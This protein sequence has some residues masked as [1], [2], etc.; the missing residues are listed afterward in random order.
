MPDSVIVEFYK[1]VH[2]REPTQEEI[3][4]L[5]DYGSNPKRSKLVVT[6]PPGYWVKRM[7]KLSMDTCEYFQM[8]N[9]V[10]VHSVRQFSFI[11]SDNPRLI[12]PPKHN[13]PFMGVGLVT[14][15]AVKIVP[16]N[17]HICLHMYDVGERWTTLHMETDDKDSIRF[18]NYNIAR[19]ARR[20]IFSS[21][22]GKLEVII[23]KDRLASVPSKSHFSID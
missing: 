9:W 11:T 7:L 21:H 17:S 22:R 23:K 19:E 16:I 14:P 2:K 8:M 4:D 3:D 12:I 13:D 10:F 1:K 6:F 5:R 18:I 20:Y 15:G